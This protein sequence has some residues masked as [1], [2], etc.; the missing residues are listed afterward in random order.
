MGEPRGRVISSSS[1]RLVAEFGRWPV[2]YAAAKWGIEGFSEVVPKEAGPLGV[3]MTIKRLHRSGE[4]RANRLRA[5]RRQKKRARRTIH[6]DVGPSRQSTRVRPA[7]FSRAGRPLTDL[8]KDFL[9]S[10]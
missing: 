7:I 1:P 6:N 8:L 4:A 2:P 10:A 9:A 3:K 5:L